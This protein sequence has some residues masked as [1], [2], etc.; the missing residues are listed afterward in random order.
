MA[1]WFGVPGTSTYSVEVLEG[2]VEA[3]QLPVQGPPPTEV[4]GD[5][6]V[7]LL[8]QG[9]AQTSH[10]GLQVG[11]GQVW[12]QAQGQVH[13]IQGLDLIWSPLLVPRSLGGDEGRGG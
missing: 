9:V 1:V 4:E 8:G 13:V 12:L 3:A 11:R 5:G 7:C 10:L 2:Q 6:L